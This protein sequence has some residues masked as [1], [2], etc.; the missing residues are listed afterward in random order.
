LYE[1]IISLNEEAKNEGENLDL[2][3][4]TSVLKFLCQYS[5]SLISAEVDVEAAY[6]VLFAG[7]ID[8]SAQDIED[9]VLAIVSPIENDEQ[10]KPETKLVM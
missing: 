7:V 8:L 3:D 4:E 6:N 2:N 1:Y 9:C 10:L 5:G